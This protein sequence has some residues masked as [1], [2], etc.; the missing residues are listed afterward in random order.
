VGDA[1]YD[2]RMA[3]AANVS[4]LG[5]SFGVSASDELE[6]AGAMAVVDNFSDLLAYFPP[7]Q[8]HRLSPTMAAVL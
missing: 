6:Q 7:L 1:L 8:D 2:M 3:Q 4:A 5:V